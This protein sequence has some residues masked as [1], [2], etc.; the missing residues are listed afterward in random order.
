MI[1]VGVDGGASRTRVLALESGSGRVGR[2]EGA[3]SSP[4][5]W[6]PERALALLKDLLGRAI[7]AAGGG[8]EAPVSAAFALA[9]VDTEAE[10]IRVSALLAEALPG[11]SIRLINDTWA[12][13]WGG[14]PEGGPAVAVVAGTGANAAARDASGRLFTLRG[15]GYEQGNYGGGIDLARAALHA[16]FRSEEGSGAGTRLEPEL[17]ALTGARDYD[18]LAERLG[19]GQAAPSDEVFR[20]V[21]AIPPLVVRL[22]GEGDAVAQELLLE[23]GRKLAGSARAAARQAG[24]SAPVGGPALPVVLAGGLFRPENPWLEDALRLELHRSLPAADCRRAAR[25]PVRGAL[26]LSLEGGPALE[27]AERERLRRL[28]LEGEAVVSG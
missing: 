9:G 18:E 16:A 2:A 22:A 8:P 14:A 10:R 11:W 20:L 26:L 5:V 13:L 15:K 28:A 1:Y 12:A 6:G 3:G 21:A 17:L 23:M 4:E 7:A 25:E 24:L 27:R 19:G